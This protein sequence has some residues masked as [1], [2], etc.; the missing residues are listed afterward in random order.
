VEAE[1]RQVVA[2]MASKATQLRALGDVVGAQPNGFGSY[3]GDVEPKEIYVP[4]RV[5]A[6]IIYPDERIHWGKSGPLMPLVG[7]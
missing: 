5:S 7:F 6:I 2:A 1:A 3:V 4:G